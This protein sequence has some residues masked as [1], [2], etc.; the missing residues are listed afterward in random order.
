[1][2]DKA[3]LQQQK[4]TLRARQTLPT[5]RVSI[6]HTDPESVLP[7]LLLSPFPAGPGCSQCLSP[8][9]RA[10]G[11][12]RPGAEHLQEALSLQV[13]FGGGGVSHKQVTWFPLTCQTTLCPGLHSPAVTPASMPHQHRKQEIPSQ[14]L[15]CY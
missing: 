5:E 2:P 14:H 8:G 9:D 7:T 10:E 6:T 4:P 1:M 13:S 15:V 11:C 3:E 12:P